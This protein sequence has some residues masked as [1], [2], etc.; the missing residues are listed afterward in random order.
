[1]VGGPLFLKNR[2]KMPRKLFRQCKTRGIFDENKNGHLLE[3]VAVKET[4]GFYIEPSRCKAG[5]VLFLAR[6]LQNA[7]K[8]RLENRPNKGSIGGENPKSPGQKLRASLVNSLVIG[9][10]H[11][12][13]RCKS[14]IYN[15]L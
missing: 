5:A 2:K 1:M 7:T 15:G 4:D 3:Q 14:L 11:E 10:G 8:R 9:F 12:K 13:T 6:T